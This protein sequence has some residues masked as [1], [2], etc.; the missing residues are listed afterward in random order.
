MVSQL[1][2]LASDCLPFACLSQMICSSRLP[3][4]LCRLD[5]RPHHHHHQQ[6]QQ[7]QE[8]QTSYMGSAALWAWA[9]PR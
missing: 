4:Q 9:P 3:Q 6:Q 8:D 1:R 7:Q 5:T 2:L